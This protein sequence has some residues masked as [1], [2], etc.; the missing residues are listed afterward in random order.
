EG[1]QK[2]SMFVTINKDTD[3]PS[4]PN[5]E[6]NPEKPTG[7]VDL[8]NPERAWYKEEHP[9]VFL[10]PAPQEENRA[11]VTSH[12]TLMESG[13]VFENP[14]ALGAALKEGKNILRLEAWD[15]AGNVVKDKGLPYRE[16]IIYLDTKAPVLDTPIFTETKAR[17]AFR[18]LTNSLDFGNFAKEAVKVS[19]P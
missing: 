2:Q 7:N 5:S 12:Y 15:E 19:I 4:F 1:T 9:E 17:S 13:A 16:Q 18:G 3:A 11:P 14:V 6:I 10:L 8:V